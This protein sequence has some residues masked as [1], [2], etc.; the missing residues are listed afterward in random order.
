M[1]HGLRPGSPGAREG[2]VGTV[3]IEDAWLRKDGCRDFGASR[4]AR[5]PRAQL[6]PT[7]STNLVPRKNGLGRRRFAPAQPGDG[8]VG[9]EGRRDENVSDARPKRA[10]L[11]AGEKPPAPCQRATARSAP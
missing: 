3:G 6:R 10:R 8:T 5:L 4:S 11:P 7:F 1:R 2:T 9:L